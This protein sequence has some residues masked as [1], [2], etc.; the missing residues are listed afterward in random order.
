M[1]EG[2]SGTSR[3]W[4]HQ[5]GSAWLTSL[6]G[7]FAVGIAA[8]VSGGALARGLKPDGRGLVAEAM[9]WP[10]LLIAT[11]SVVN[12]QAL[13]YFAARVGR[14][15]VPAGLL[16]SAMLSLVM[17]PAAVAINYLVLGAAGKQSLLAANIYV[18]HIPFSLALTCF[19]APVLAEGRLAAYWSIRIFT[20]AAG[21]V[22]V[23]LLIAIHRLTPSNYMVSVVLVNVL[24]AVFAAF[25]MGRAG[26]GA[27]RVERPL[28]TDI[29]RFGSKVIIVATPSQIRQRLD[30]M[31]MSV[32]FSSASLG[33]Y[34]TAIAWA[35]IVGMAGV[36][37]STTMFSRSVAAGGGTPRDLSALLIQYRRACVVIA[38][39]GLVLA[40]AAPL[41]MWMVFGREFLPAA[42]PAMILCI[43]AVI[44]SATGLL[45]ELARGIGRPGM[46]VIPE[47][48]GAVVAAALLAL[49]LLPLQA[50]GAA[51]VSV[52][53]Q[54]VVM[55]AFVI[56][57]AEKFCVDRLQLLPNAEDL[58]A[59]Y[60]IARSGVTRM[61]GRRE[62]S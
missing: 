16:A 49:L 61:F 33:L 9:L 29:V 4:E 1:S 60:V 11:T 44:S 55:Y 12:L 7:N 48:I 51:L 57:F 20:A 59:V 34:A 43:G 26:M 32:L 18:M 47:T 41:G 17:M 24:A 5:P 14:R 2:G 42:V 31:M 62:R 23:L 36:G 3:A 21:A 52:I 13:T 54:S 53:G 28:I 46:P 25:A 56:R 19:A 22:A 37:L 15:S 8:L 39:T 27:F 40:G 6:A 30:L 58:R 45:D 35:A 10:T 50:I 38:V